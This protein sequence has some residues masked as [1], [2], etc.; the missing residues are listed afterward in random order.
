MNRLSSGQNPGGP[1]KIRI[2]LPQYLGRSA[3]E[4]VLSG[5]SRRI[6]DV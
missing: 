5:I 1:D 4:E 2:P 3:L 6:S